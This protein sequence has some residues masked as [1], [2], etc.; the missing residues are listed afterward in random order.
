MYGHHGGGQEAVGPEML[1]K[2]FDH[3]GKTG[4]G[5]GGGGDEPMPG[6]L[7]I[8]MVDPHDGGDRI[9]RMVSPWALILKGEERMTLSAPACK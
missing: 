7:I 1:H 8:L 5:A 3:I 9:L 6:M 2:R 4:G